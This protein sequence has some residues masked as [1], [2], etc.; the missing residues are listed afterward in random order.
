ML[1]LLVGLSHR[2]LKGAPRFNLGAGSS[3]AVMGL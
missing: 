2:N 1:E 3:T